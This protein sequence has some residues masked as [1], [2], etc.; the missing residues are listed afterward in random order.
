MLISPSFCFGPWVMDGA[1][2]HTTLYLSRYQTKDIYQ[3]VYYEYIYVGVVVVYT[4]YVRRRGRTMA[5]HHDLS[6]LLFPSSS[7]GGKVKEGRRPHHH[8]HQGLPELL[9]HTCA[10]CVLLKQQYKTGYPV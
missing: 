4:A 6:C 3:A 10:V 1:I 8:Y 9:N 7:S 5:I 2:A